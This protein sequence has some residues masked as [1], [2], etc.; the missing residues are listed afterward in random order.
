[1]LGNS[2]STT[3]KPGEER[4]GAIPFNLSGVTDQKRGIIALVVSWQEDKGGGRSWD[5]RFPAILEVNAGGI[6]LDQAFVCTPER[7]GEIS[8]AGNF[9]HVLRVIATDEG[10]QKII[11]TTKPNVPGTYYVADGDLIC[12][13]L[14]G[15]A[16][17]ANLQAAAAECA[18]EISA[19]DQA[20]RLRSWLEDHLPPEQFWN[21]IPPQHLWEQN[22]NW[23]EL[24]TRWIEFLQASLYTKE[25]VTAFA[26][27][28]AK[29]QLDEILEVLQRVLG[30]WSPFEDVRSFL[31]HKLAAKAE[32]L[33]RQRWGAIS[34][35][36]R[37]L[38]QALQM[39]WGS[40]GRRKEIAAALA[41]LCQKLDQK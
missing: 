34:W 17:L 11:F 12:R 40:F 30:D 13:F 28:S 6:V 38:V 25:R 37:R 26:E 18:A 5:Q 14:V 8:N 4:E 21:Q 24:L 41:A 19:R 10:G 33:A 39:S 36:V 35:P 20:A 31:E 22:L 15:Q 23:F 16:E 1:M 7:M 2:L 3:V 32:A 9:D 29:Q 27:E